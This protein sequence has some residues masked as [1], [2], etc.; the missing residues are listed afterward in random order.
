M[1]TAKAYQVN[2]L[3]CAEALN[4]LLVVCL[5]AVV[6][7]NAELSLLLLKSPAKPSS[8]SRPVLQRPH[9][10]GTL[11]AVRH[12]LRNAPAN[13]VNSTSEAIVREGGLHHTRQR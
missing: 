12:T 1:Q 7:K 6:R 10:R 9:C 4:E 13:L 2:R 5:V 11:T 8:V 3:L